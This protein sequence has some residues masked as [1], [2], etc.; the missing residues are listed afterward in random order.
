[1]WLPD[2]ADVARM[3]DVLSRHVGALGLPGAGRPRWSCSTRGSRTRTA[4]SRRGVA[5][6]RRTSSRRRDADAGAAVRQGLPRRA[7]PAG[8]LASRTGRAAAR[9]SERAPAASSTWSCGGSPRTHGSRRCRTWSPRGGWPASCR[10]SVRDVLG[11]SPGDGLRTTVVRY[12]P[13]ASATLRARGRV[14]AG[15][16]AVFAKHLA[17][18]KV[19]AASRPDTR[20][21]GP[22]RTRRAGSGSPS[23]WPP[24]RYEECCGPAGSRGV[25][26]LRPCAP[27]RLPDATAPLGSAAGGP[28]RVSRATHAR[29][30]PST[31]CWPRRRRRRPSW[32]GRHPVGRPAGDRPRGRARRD[33][34][35]TPSTSACA[36]CTATS[37]STSSSPRRQG[38]VLVDLD[39]MVQRPP[40]GRPR[41][42]P[43]GP[44]AAR[45]PATGRPRTSRRGLLSSYAA[46][47]G[48]RD[49]RA[50]CSGS[51][52]DAEFLNRCYRHLRRHAPG[53]QRT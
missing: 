49:R 26:C 2:L 14:E 22:R 52:A 45:T 1:M 41:R 33:A 20:R 39:S 46:A 40:R 9:R 28:A 30:S 44:G 4:R 43:R 8:G 53:W 48:D 37:T 12:Q 29:A 11:S 17:D 7:A 13:E 31:T 19:A 34:A 51:C 5:A 15:A 21:C 36:R 35:A 50:R 32:P 3:T 6:G 18:G 38:P 23:R 10:R 27:D 24:I 47:R 16:P 42:V 25:P